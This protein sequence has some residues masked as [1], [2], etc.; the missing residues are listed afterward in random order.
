MKGELWLI[1]FTSLL[2]NK[3]RTLLSMLGIIIGVATVIAVVGIGAGA[4][5]KI[6]EQFKNLSVTSLIVMANRGTSS[7]KLDVGDV[8]YVEKNAEFIK[9]GTG[10]V[11]GSATISYQK[12]NGSYT[13]MGI[14]EKTF[15]VSNLDIAYGRLITAKEITDRGKV[16]IIGT[17]I[18]DE[19]WGDTAADETAI[20]ETISVNGK[21]LEVIGILKENG[22]TGMVA[23]DDTVYIPYSTA[24]KVVL[25]A[26]AR[27]TLYFNA[28]DLDSLLIAQ[29]EVTSLLRTAHRLKASAEDDFRV[30]DAG[31]MVA[32][33]SATADTMSFLL[34][35]AATIVLIVSGIG[36]M[37]VMFVTV[38]ERT[39]EIGVLK[40][41]GAKNKD[42]LTQFLLESIILTLIGGMI[43]IVLGQGTI[44]LLADYGAL[45]SWNG[46]I[47]GFCFSVFVGIFFGFYPALKASRLDPVDALR[48]E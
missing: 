19:L 32:S 7:S 38:A 18:V 33:A 26:R 46:V 17:G 40:A 1:A 37:N 29:E 24:E 30:R 13:V 36:I 4:Q 43:G 39:K 48:S 15:E 6:E 28:I 34:T 3:G 25:G 12:E 20:G 31:S 10:T 42:I 16:A 22:S 35:S 27:K 5:R 11:S 45:Y 21:R 44:P 8:A 2:S 14:D 41:I 23:Y 9:N 47:L